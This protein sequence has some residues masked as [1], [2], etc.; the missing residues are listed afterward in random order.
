M[1]LLSPLPRPR[2]TGFTLIELLV[3][4]SII[5]VLAAGSFGAYTKIVGGVRV[6]EARV[7][8]L[9]VANAVEGYSGD[10]SR[11]PKPT[12]ATAGE[13]TTTS[14]EAAEGIV[15]VLIGKEGEGEAPQNPRNT[16]Y[17][18][19]IKPAKARGDKKT[20]DAE[21]SDKWV[22]GLVYEDE[23]YSIVDPWGNYFKIKLDSNYSKDLENPNTEQVAD[24]RILM[25][26]SVLVWS[27]G[28]DADG[29]TWTDNPM[30]WD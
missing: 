1:K 27:A 18:E 22:N 3:V 23:N 14:T 16:D 24:G 28:K 26:R 17:T 30:S 13:D 15:K 21:G 25:R 2:A 4:I 6:K 9:G 19:G 5:A 11:L 7:M 20:A 10:Y 29:D 12:S 8:A